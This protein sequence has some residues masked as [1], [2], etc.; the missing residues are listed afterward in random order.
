M[1]NWE[2]WVVS[3]NSS[4]KLGILG[5]KRVVNNYSQGAG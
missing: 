5:S 1:Y 2:V 4:Q 3:G